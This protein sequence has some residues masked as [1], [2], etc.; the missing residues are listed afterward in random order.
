[1][2]S[3][4]VACKRFDE[5]GT[6]A[7]AEKNLTRHTWKLDKYLRNG[8]DETSQLLISSYEETYQDG[9]A[10]LR[11]YNFDGQAYTENGNWEL[12]KD[13]KQ[14]KIDGVSSL[15]LTAQTSTVSTSD[16]EILKLKKK[17]FWYYFENGSDR[18]EFRFV[19]K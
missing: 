9:G 18:H 3:T 13:T 17:E 1:M 16:I 10:L 5:G 11:T 15:Q 12:K 2:S 19:P 14:I 4:L 8:T 7:R 6:V